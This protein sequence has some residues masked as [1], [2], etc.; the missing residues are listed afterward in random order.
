MIRKRKLGSADGFNRAVSEIVAR[1][2]GAAQIIEDDAEAAEPP[3]K[4]T[5]RKPTELKPPRETKEL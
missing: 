5:E 2:P 4:L 1:K 3:R